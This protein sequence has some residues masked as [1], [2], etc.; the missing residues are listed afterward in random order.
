M[1]AGLLKFLTFQP[2]WM[3]HKPIS[4]TIINNLLLYKKPSA[5]AH[6][7]AIQNIDS[8]MYIET[9]KFT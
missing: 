2:T 4:V 6:L 1:T 3:I 9:W 7:V 8:T 5:L